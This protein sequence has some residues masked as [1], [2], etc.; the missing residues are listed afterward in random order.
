[1]KKIL[2][3]LTLLVS[4]LVSL[5]SFAQA[6]SNSI[7]VSGSRFTY[8]LLRQWIQDFNEENPDAV[9]QIVPRETPFAEQ[10]NLVINAH[11]LDT[12]EIREGYE[13]IKLGRYVI[14]PI[15]NEQNTLAR[16]YK[17][18]PIRQKE[19]KELYFDPF[20]EEVESSEIKR[21][22]K[23]SI[24]LYTRQ[25]IACANTAFAAYY[26]FKAK[27]IKGRPIAG[28]DKHLLYAI[29]KDTSGV[30]YSIPS[31]FYDL[32]TRKLKKGISILKTESLANA[33]ATE[34]LDL[35]NLDSLTTYLEK[36]VTSA[37]FPVTYFHISLKKDVP[38]NS[39]E[40]KFLHY[41]LTKGQTRLHQFGFLNPEE[42]VRAQSIQLI[43][44]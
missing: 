27:D 26:G 29:A 44:F 33:V 8:D 16:L 34:K 28:E 15:A 18:K 36:N 11:N 43:S 40:R 20:Q 19:L 32:Q 6:A 14:L 12:V 13:Y 23:Q 42:P 1:M 10:A 31:I 9:I 22:K 30:T 41:I 21:V 7:T 4:S 17:N 39:I 38:E 25:R 3:F 2:F 37:D 35:S 24:Q 5:P